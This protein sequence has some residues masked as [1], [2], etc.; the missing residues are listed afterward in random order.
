LINGEETSGVTLFRF[1]P[2]ID[3]GD[4][5]DQTA[6]SITRDDTIAEVLVKATDSTSSMIER[7]FLNFLDGTAPYSPQ[8]HNAATFGGLRR[9]EDGLIDWRLSS[10][11]VHDFVRAQS[12]PYPGAYTMTKD[13]RLI[14]V[15]RT[16]EF[17][18]PYSG[19]PGV[20]GERTAD[21]PL[22]ACGEGAVIVLEVGL[23]D[24][25]DR[26]LTDLG[27]GSRLMS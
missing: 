7:S 27:W 4:V 9:P 25:S 20:V 6:F 10:R 26:D 11:R 22:V 15:W 16:A 13:R 12:R 3:D 1:T 21:G 17:P 19:V 8:D 14:R 23:E 18:F 2:G 5:I 24:S